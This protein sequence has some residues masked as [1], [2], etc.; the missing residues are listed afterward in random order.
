MSSRSLWSDTHRA[1][2]NHPASS[3]R[4]C[5]R[6]ARRS[7]R[8][9]HPRDE[10]PTPPPPQPMPMRPPP[11][12]LVRRRADR[13]VAP[14]RTSLA[15]RM[16]MVTGRCA[17]TGLRSPRDLPHRRRDRCCRWRAVRAGLAKCGVLFEVLWCCVRRSRLRSGGFSRS[18]AS[19]GFLLAIFRVTSVV[20]GPG[21]D[22]QLT[23]ARFCVDLFLLSRGNNG[24]RFKAR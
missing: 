18:S 2:I 21:Q 23:P 15:R 9:T 8:Y 16:T 22:H 17:G 4:L 1:R 12:N 7:A 6:S 19:C 5:W 3:C 20:R 14:W 13:R 11:K 24:R 10:P